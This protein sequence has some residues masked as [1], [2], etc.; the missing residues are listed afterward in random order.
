MEGRIL[1]H[2]RIVGDFGWVGR[3]VVVDGLGWGVWI[4][5]L[6]TEERCYKLPAIYTV[7]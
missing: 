6:R 2:A 7:Y 3:L 4:E 5:G 1:C